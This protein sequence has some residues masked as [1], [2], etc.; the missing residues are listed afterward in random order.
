MGRSVSTPSGSISCFDNIST[1]GYT[2]ICPDCGCSEA[3][4]AEKCENCEGDLT[5]TEPTYDDYLAGV[6]FDDYI[7]DLKTQLV[8]KYPSLSECDEWLDREDHAMLEN[9]KIYV[10]VSEYMGLLAI[11]MVAKDDVSGAERYLR[12]RENSFLKSFGSLRKVGT[13]SNGE[14]VFETKGK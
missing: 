6:Y 11:W 14:S 9:D 1:F 8:K 13:F 4:N 5:S 2:K 3:F 10:G 12:A 7:D